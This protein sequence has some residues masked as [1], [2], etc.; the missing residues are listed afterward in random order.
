MAPRPARPLRVL[1]PMLAA[2]ALLAPTAGWAGSAVDDA[3]AAW[4]ANGPGVYVAPAA[5]GQPLSSGDAQR[6]DQAIKTASTPI[7]AAALGETSPGQADADLTELIDRLH[8]DGTYVVIGTR[9]FLARSDVPGVEGQTD[10]LE[11]QATEARPGS[12]LG[13]LTEFVHLV[14]AA[15]G[16]AG[17]AGSSGSGSGSGNG[18]G[19]GISPWIP[20]VIVVGLG[21]L[22][23][24]GLRRGRRRQEQ[25]DEAA[26]A[27]VRAAA[28]EDVTAL[29]EELQALDVPPAAAAA[30]VTDYRAGLDAY[31]RA[32]QLLARARHPQELATVTSAL[33]EGRWHLACVRARLAGRPLPERRPP[34]FFNPRHGPSVEDVE[35]SPPGGEPRRVPVCAADADRLARGDDPDARLVSAGGRMV[36]YW[37][38]P[39]SYGPYAGGFFGGWGGG[40]F[41]SGLLLGEL[42]GGPMLG[43]GWGWGGYGAYDAGYEAGYDAGQ[44]PGGDFA[45]GFDD[46]GGGW[47]GGD[48]GGGDPGGGDWGGGGD[49]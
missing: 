16:S 3:V 14:D 6:L 45:A 4:R 41:L 19:G 47:G 1:L 13:Q 11:R 15:A 2:F 23:V 28:E 33:E 29:G 48:W 5:H 17:A 26:F 34:C 40:S 31:D 32:K 42:I 10:Q 43:G 36:P 8:R 46:P 44:D 20:V 12:A 21:A 24:G 30:A 18:N 39:A 49:W 25:Q 38:G 7:Y 27:D 37:A 35:W 22:L 9:G